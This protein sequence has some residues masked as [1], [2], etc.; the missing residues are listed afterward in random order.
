MRRT[1]Y[2]RALAPLAVAG[3]VALSCASNSNQNSG[4]LASDQTLRFPIIDDIATLDPAH[5]I[6]PTDVTISANVFGGL[7]KFD[8]DLKEVPD[9]ASAMPTVSSDG[10]MYTFTLRKEA[11]FS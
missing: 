10:L 7:Y 9:I 4:G 8:K 6:L 2:W 1:N 11:K 3:L 5:V